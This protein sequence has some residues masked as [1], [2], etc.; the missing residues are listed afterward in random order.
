MLL[1]YCLILLCVY[2]YVWPEAHPQA[3]KGELTELDYVRWAARNQ[4]T[5]VRATTLALFV[6]II[7]GALAW[8]SLKTSMLA[9]DFHPMPDEIVVEGEA[10]LAQNIAKS[11]LEM[12]IRA[13]GFGKASVT[14]LNIYII[15]RNEKER[16][17][18]TLVLKDPLL[19]EGNYEGSTTPTPVK[20]DR[21]DESSLV[22]AW[23][24]CNCNVKNIEN[25]KV[26]PIYENMWGQDKTP[27][28]KRYSL[29]IVNHE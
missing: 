7:G 18:V 20:R 12:R 13:E 28:G 1:V 26:E 9:L 27:K 21:Y 25:I 15:R 6:A 2:H 24:D 16:L 23:T 22:Q 3:T 19:I 8:G 10:A 17:L 14:E 29:D 5:G 11:A 4:A